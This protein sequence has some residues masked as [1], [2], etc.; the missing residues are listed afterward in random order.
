M[1]AIP[2]I[3]ALLLMLI[4]SITQYFIIDSITVTITENLMSL[5]PLKK[6]KQA[7]DAKPFLKFEL[8]EE[9]EAKC[10]F[11]LDVSAQKFLCFEYSDESYGEKRLNKNFASSEY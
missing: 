10:D 11:K 6:L 2:S 9:P 5:Q 7:W 1:V 8:L 3:T 4:C